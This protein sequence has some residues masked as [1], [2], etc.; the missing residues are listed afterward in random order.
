LAAKIRKGEIDVRADI[1]GVYQYLWTFYNFR[2][3]PESDF[4]RKVIQRNLKR[5]I[6]I[7]RKWNYEK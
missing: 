2:I 1:L 5:I 3:Q 4:K 6:A 7:I